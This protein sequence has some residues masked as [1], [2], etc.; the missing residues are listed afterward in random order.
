M[1]VNVLVGL[2]LTLRNTITGRSTHRSM[3]FSES[4]KG[5]S[6]FP[7]PNQRVAGNDMD[8][9]TR[10]LLRV[11]D[12]LKWLTPWSLTISSACQRLSEAY[13]FPILSQPYIKLT[14]R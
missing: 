14:R 7:R 10:E 4:W 8:L 12:W 1:S 3:K 6:L 11:S 9:P 2:F 13:H 5:M